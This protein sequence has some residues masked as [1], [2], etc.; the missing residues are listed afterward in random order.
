MINNYIPR[1]EVD[2]YTI[3]QG[4]EMESKLSPTMAAPVHKF[5]MQV[6]NGIQIQLFQDLDIRFKIFTT[7]VIC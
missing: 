2:Y 5:A 1:S 6:N 3:P 4:L 7:R